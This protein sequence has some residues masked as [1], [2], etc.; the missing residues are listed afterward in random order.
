MGYCM[1]FDSI[2]DRIIEARDLF[3]TKKGLLFPNTLTFKCAVVHDEHFYDH[4]VEYWNEVYGVPMTTMKKW[5][6][7]EP[8]IRIVDPTLIVSKVAKVI[9]FDLSKDKYQDIIAIDRAIEI[10]FLGEC[11]ANGISFWFETTF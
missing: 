10:D 4:K 1:H 11:K 7:H 9:T 2:L 8:I 5:I 6:S 3:L